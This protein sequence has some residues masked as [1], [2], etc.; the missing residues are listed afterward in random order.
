M[1]LKDQFLYQ[2]ISKDVWLKNG[3]KKILKDGIEKERKIKC[4]EENKKIR[5]KLLPSL[6]RIVFS[7]SAR[8]I[9]SLIQQPREKK[10]LAL[11]NFSR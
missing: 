11:E 5:K 7:L 8:A 9:S 6:F 3:K 10:N 2:I 4:W 1:V